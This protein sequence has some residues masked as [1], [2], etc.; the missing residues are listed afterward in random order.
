MD[1]IVI[2]GQR[3]PVG[4]EVVLWTEPKGFNGYGMERVVHEEQDRRTG[5]TLSRVVSGRRYQRRGS[6]NVDQI[7]IH[8][9][10][11]PMP[12]TA[13]QTLHNDRGLSVH[14]ILADNGVAYQCLD[15]QEC[16]WHAG[17]NNGRSVGIEVCLFPDAG[18][19][20]EYYSPERCARL[21][22]APHPDIM[23]QTIQGQMRRC[24]AMP[25][26]QVAALAQL[27]AGI[28]HGL[29]R[30][31]TAVG[32]FA[33]AGERAAEIAFPR[34]SAD[35]E[36]GDRD[37]NGYVPWAFV[38]DADVS[39]QG[40]LG[41]MHCDEHRQKWDPAGLDFMALEHDV[42]EALLALRARREPG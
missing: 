41:H 18:D 2:G 33:P 15:V 6:R 17:N 22:C 11:G 20:P 27:C 19:E 14:F 21:G 12:R 30:W 29:A 4:C 13:F 38:P 5:G 23:F 8:H 24:F 28:W 37:P 1:E 25:D 3:V 39:W 16:A 35:P 9:T 34:M 10:G 40:L 7:V 31:S 36:V 42:R 26:V 32:P